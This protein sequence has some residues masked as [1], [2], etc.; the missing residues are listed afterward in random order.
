MSPWQLLRGSRAS[1][2]ALGYRVQHGAAASVHY[3]IAAAAAAAPDRS[4]SFC[5]SSEKQTMQ[6]LNGRLASYLQ[7]VQRLEAANQRLELQIQEEL[8]RKCPGELRQLDRHLRRASQLQNQ[9]GDCLSAQAQVKLQLL[10]AQLDA[11][12]LN[13]RCE[14]ERERR[15]KVEAELNDLKE[16]EAELK[17]HKLP[18][19]QSLLDNQMQNL[20]Q[21]QTQHQQNV[22]VLVAQGLGVLAVEMQTAESSD[23]L[24]QLEHLRTRSVMAAR[25]KPQ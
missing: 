15:D 23:L 1:Q 10:G 24:Q 11:F 16:L 3:S 8:N 20:V 25:Q 17:V 6:Q 21:L 18:E 9:I 19:L 5:L 2:A 12:N 7:Q 13:V 22:Q 4:R 14:N